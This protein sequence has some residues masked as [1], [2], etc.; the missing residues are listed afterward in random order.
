ML[1]S[2]VQELVINFHMTEAC[3]YCCDYC[4]ATWDNHVLS[5]ELHHDTTQVI[6]LL[7]NLA[8][9]FLHD[10]PLKHRMGYHTVRI[11]FAGG[12]PIMLGS[13]FIDALLYAK[14]LG[15]NTSIITNGHFLN[16]QILTR[17][18]SAIDMLGISFDT[19][20]YLI[21][22]SI[23]RIDRKGFWLSPDKLIDICRT[24]RGL[25]SLGKLKLNTVVNAFNWRENLLNTVQQ[26]KP[27]KWKLLRV[28]PVHNQNCTITD[29][30]YRAY[31]TRHQSLSDCIVEEDNDAM[32]QSYLMI[33]PDGCFYQNSSHG[34]GL[35][36][37]QPILA[38]GVKAAFE[39]ISFN[40]EAFSHRY[41]PSL[42]FEYSQNF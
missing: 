1:T 12:E 9:Y 40:A 4:Y 17:I 42:S 29:D 11:N 16:A 30:Q 20:D 18:S 28:L 38:V 32:W 27:D 13:R 2:K 26:I 19:G 23:G 33:N 25:N 8:A 24:Y 21:A 22:N 41:Q 35:T 14:S 34:A 3:N 15:F 5:S 37:S 36:Q 31:V 39:Q 7:D 10:N 6:H